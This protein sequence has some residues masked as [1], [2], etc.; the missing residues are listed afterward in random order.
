M[1][2][3]EKLKALYAIRDAIMSRAYRRPAWFWNEAGLCANYR[4]VSY[5]ICKTAPFHFMSAFGDQVRTWPY[6]T[7]DGDYIVPVSPGNKNVELAGQAYSTKSL[8]NRSTTY[9]KLRMDLLKHIIT[10]LEMIKHGEEQQ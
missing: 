5:T 2:T 7:G 9:G 4:A 8:Y 6:W 1:T 10:S 3:N